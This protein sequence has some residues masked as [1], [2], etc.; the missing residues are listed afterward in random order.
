[1]CTGRVNFIIFFFLRGGPMFSKEYE[2]FEFD[3]VTC[4]E[5]SGVSHILLLT[6]IIKKKIL[7][8]TLKFYI[9]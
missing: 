1:M 4:V 7:N 2:F 6:V 5:S 8:E 3:T 9:T